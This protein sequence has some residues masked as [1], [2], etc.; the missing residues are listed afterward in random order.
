MGLET[1]IHTISFVHK[2]YSLSQRGGSAAPSLKWQS[3]KWLKIYFLFIR[4]IVLRM[5][6]PPLNRIIS[7]LFLFWFLNNNVC[8]VRDFLL[9]FTFNR[10]AMLL[11]W[12]TMP[13]PPP[14]LC[15]TQRSIWICVI[16]LYAVAAHHLFPYSIAHL[17]FYRFEQSQQKITLFFR[18]DFQVFDLVSF[19]VPISFVERR[20][21]WNWKK[22]IV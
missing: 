17:H 15:N 13:P 3:I 11:N 1:R 19:P 21:P 9:F 14:L 12:M 2:Q 10:N 18:M 6:S 5:P 20:A 8:C 16:D 4:R 22:K 7:I